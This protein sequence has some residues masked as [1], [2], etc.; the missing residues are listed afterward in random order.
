MRKSTLLTA[1]LVAT[2]TPGALLAQGT[3]D[4]KY[5]GAE[6]WNYDGY[7]VG[8]YHGVVPYPGGPTIDMYCVDAAHEVTSA[9]NPWTAYVTPLTGTLT[10]GDLNHAYLGDAGWDAY[11]KAAYLTTMFYNPDYASNVQIAAIHSAIWTI[12]GAVVGGVAWPSGF[13]PPSSP[14]GSTSDY[15]YWID[16]ANANYQVFRTDNADQYALLSDIKGPDDASASQEFLVKR[17]NVVP[18]PT[19]WLMLLTGLVGIVGMT[20]LKGARA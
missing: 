8:P 18:E 11:W 16:Q 13:T 9:D 7:Y 5:V 6:G 15:N 20:V 2:L 10:A 12:T 17:S 19:T 14:A 3:V 1:L 4:V